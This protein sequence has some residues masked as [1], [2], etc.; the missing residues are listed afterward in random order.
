MKTFWVEYE[1]AQTYWRKG[2]T[3]G[4]D[5]KAESQEDAKKKAREQADRAHGAKVDTFNV[6]Y[7]S[8]GK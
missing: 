5:I 8:K 7:I 3:V 1:W 4:C 6:V 2:G